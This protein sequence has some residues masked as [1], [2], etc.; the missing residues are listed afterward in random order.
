MLTPKP[1]NPPISPRA[2]SAAVNKTAERRVGPF[3]GIQGWMLTIT[4][5]ASLAILTLPFLRPDGGLR[6]PLQIVV[7]EPQ[8]TGRAD[9]V[10]LRRQQLLLEAIR[11][12]LERHLNGRR[13]LVASKLF[14]P[15]DQALEVARRAGADEVLQVNVQNTSFG[16]RVGLG[17]QRTIDGNLVWQREEVQIA[18]E[19][20]RLVDRRLG[21]EIQKAYIRYQ[22]P[23]DA[24]QLFAE[25]VDYEAYLRLRVEAK[26]TGDPSGF[27][28]ELDTLRRNSPR[29][30]EATLWSAKLVA[31]QPD[32]ALLLL[33]QSSRM[34]PADPRPFE[35][36]LPLLIELDRI[37]EARQ[38]LARLEDLRKGDPA[39]HS[40]RSLLDPGSEK[41]ALPG[42]VVGIP[43][44]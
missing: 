38:Q 31:D 9:G 41:D 20:L 5:C 17:R 33:K 14:V 27:L 7:Q 12:T 28:A 39:L 16:A 8:V 35:A 34:A 37:A 29:F 44:Q 2:K 24:A 23:P 3:R 18:G 22:R 4:L 6:G 13:G 30:F 1:P 26:K 21:D 40:W 42:A 19:D 36:S 10:D 32:R 43:G 25:A 15:A 11:D